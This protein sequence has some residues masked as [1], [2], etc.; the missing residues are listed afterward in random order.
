MADDRLGWGRGGRVLLL[1]A[2]CAGACALVGLRE[3]QKPNAKTLLHLSLSPVAV[4]CRGP[5]A[6]ARSRF[7]F[8]VHPPC[9]LMRLAT[10]T[11]QPMCHPYLNCFVA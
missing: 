9:D 10:C 4:A 11:I 2:C 8:S 7:A 5:A 6:V 1:R 3:V